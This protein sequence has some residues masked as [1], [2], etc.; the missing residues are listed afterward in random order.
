MVIRSWA[1]SWADAF[2]R[3]QARLGVGIVPR[4]Y[5]AC[6]A[7]RSPLA[8]LFKTQTIADLD[9]GENIEPRHLSEAI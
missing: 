3:E 5:Y 7:D 6:E 4:I 8:T 1:V 9:G 2:I